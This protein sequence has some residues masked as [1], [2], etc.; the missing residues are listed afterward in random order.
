MNIGIIGHRGRLGSYLVSQGCSP[1]LCEVTFPETIKRTIDEV[2]PDAII[3][4]AGFTDVDKCE[5]FPDQAVKVNM[6]GAFNVMNAFQGRI[7][8]ISSDYIW[9]GKSGPYK[10]DAKA[11][12]LNTYGWTKWGMEMLAGTF[13]NVLVV[14][15]TMLYGSEMKSDFVSKIITQLNEKDRIEVPIN[16]IGNPTYVPHLGTALLDLM[17]MEWR[18]KVVNVSGMDRMS[19]YHFAL[20]IAEM[21]GLEPKKIKV[22]HYNL[23]TAYANRPLKAGFV[24]DRAESWNIPLYDTVSGLTEYQEKFL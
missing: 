18:A 22:S 12:P 6:R 9:N 3:N 20:L 16:L 8:Q 15:T 1:L 19:R 24:L 5:L 7:I 14:R 2:K 10:E 11:D 21:F 4:C 17:K 13:K 23:L